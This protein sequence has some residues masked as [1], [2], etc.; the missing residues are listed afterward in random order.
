MNKLKQIEQYLEN[1]PKVISVSSSDLGI[2]FRVTQTGLL[3]IQTIKNGYESTYL[4][5]QQVKYLSQYLKT[6]GYE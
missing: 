5:E 4:N 1:C 6:L 3:E 2:S